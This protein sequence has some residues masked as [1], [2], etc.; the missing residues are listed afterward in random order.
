MLVKDLSGARPRLGITIVASPAAEMLVSLHFFLDEQLHLD[1]EE[2]KEWLDGVRSSLSPDLHAKLRASR[3]GLGKHCMYLW[4][5]Q[6]EIAAEE[7]CERFLTRLAGTD[8]VLLRQALLGDWERL[9][10]SPE[11]LDLMARAARGDPAALGACV[12]LGGEC[13]AA[14]EAELRDILTRDPEDDKRQLIALL[15]GWY[16]QVFKHH[17]ARLTAILTRD[18]AAKRRLAVRLTPLRQIEV[19]T[20]GLQYTPEPGITRVLLIPSVVCRPWVLICAYRDTKIF[21]CS[22]AE[23]SLSE[24]AEPASVRLLTLAKALGDERRLQALQ[25][26]AARGATLQELADSL[27]V[28]KSLMHHH[29]VTLR[30]AGLVRL[31]MGG[32]RHYELREETLSSLPGLLRGLLARRNEDHATPPLP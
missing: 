23:E 3:L 13:V 16:E 10:A 14:S 7:S 28:G 4:P 24:H 22:V 26:L 17:E 18:A 15:R 2:G 5:L 31:Q 27:G 32:D 29:M 12:A 11:G 8:P 21:I 1:M 30:A 20:N 25:L 19:V 9:S 6:G